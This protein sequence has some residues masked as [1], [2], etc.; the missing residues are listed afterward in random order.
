MALTGGSYSLQIKVF[1]PAIT[2][3]RILGGNLANITW[4]V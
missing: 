1:K 4:L 3:L 2:S